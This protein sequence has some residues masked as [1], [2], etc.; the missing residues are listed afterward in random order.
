PGGP[1]WTFTGSQEVLACAAITSPERHAVSESAR[2]SRADTHPNRS[3]SGSSRQIAVSSPS[4]NNASGGDGG[5]VDGV[6]AERLGPCEVGQVPA[7]VG[8]PPDRR[9]RLG[10]DRAQITGRPCLQIDHMQLAVGR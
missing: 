4:A 10:P 8:L 5:I 6:S 1:A 9:P 3:K 2:P 7:A